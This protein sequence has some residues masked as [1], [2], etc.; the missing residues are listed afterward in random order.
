MVF[1]KTKTPEERLLENVLVTS[2]GCWLWLGSTNDGGYGKFKVDG[3]TIRTHRFSYQHYK[4][5]IPRGKL[6]CHSCDVPLCCNPAHLWLG[7]PKENSED[8]CAKDRQDKA[9]TRSRNQ[10]GQFV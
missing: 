5:K 9:E 6:V 7:T 10:L 4:G 2:C 1:K 8:M 3:R